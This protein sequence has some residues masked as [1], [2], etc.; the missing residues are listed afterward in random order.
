M[1]GSVLELVVLIFVMDLGKL[2]PILVIFALIG[3]FFIPQIA[4]FLDFGC[5]LVFPI[6]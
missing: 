2:W 4:I 6:G 1:I 3:F 5:Q